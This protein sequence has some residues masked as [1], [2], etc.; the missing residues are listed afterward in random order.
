MSKTKFIEQGGTW[1]ETK[2]ILLVV[3]VVVFLTATT[4]LAVIGKRTLKKLE[5]MDAEEGG[6]SLEEVT[7]QETS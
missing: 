2:I 4:L 6:L 1:S 5:T 7:I 3:Q